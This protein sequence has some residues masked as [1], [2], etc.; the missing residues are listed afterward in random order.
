MNLW[1]SIDGYPEYEINNCGQ[2]RRI[3]SQNILRPAEGTI[4]N[5]VND[6][7][8]RFKYVKS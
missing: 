5:A 8:K 6:K 3:D 1:K 2:V 7:Y 4:S